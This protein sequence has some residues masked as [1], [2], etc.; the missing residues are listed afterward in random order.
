MLIKFANAFTK[1][2]GWLPQKLIF[3][4]KIHYE[5]K[6]VQGIRIQG[7]AI[8]I[9]NHTSLYDYAAYLFVFFSRTLR[10]QMAEVL[11]RKKLL[12]T[13][14]KLMGGIY[15]D[16]DSFDLGCVTKSEEI[17]RKGG[18]V[19]IFPEGRLPKKGEATPLEFKPGAA[20]LALMTGVPVIPVCTNG[21]YFCRKKAEVVIGVPMDVRSL[22][23]KDLSEKENLT[24]ISQ[25]MRQRI[26]ELETMLHEA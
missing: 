23:D 14:L 19:G 17:L 6:A 26:M 11:F 4:T 15:V 16:R 9:S 1:I 25:M 20:Y 12:G 13:Y 22:M 3:R 2:T 24:R 8:V 21:A 7:P 10:V 18:V 5:D